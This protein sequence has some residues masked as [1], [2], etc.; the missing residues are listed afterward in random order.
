MPRPRETVWSALRI[1]IKPTA[2]AEVAVRIAPTSAFFLGVCA[3]VGGMGISSFIGISGMAEPFGSISHYFRLRNILPGLFGL[4]I[5]L[6]PFWFFVFGFI[7]V[8][9]AITKS[10]GAYYCS[11][12]MLLPLVVF[13]PM[14]VWSVGNALVIMQQDVINKPPWLDSPLIGMWGSWKCFFA[15]VAVALAFGIHAARRFGELPEDDEAPKCAFCSYNLTGNIS[16][17]CPECGNPA[18]TT[19]VDSVQR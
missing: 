8:L 10:R 7:L 5:I 16:G 14:F 15:I 6:V 1:A 9:G 11:V 12:I 2:L 19:D 3:A 13:L 17:V 18:P 4:A